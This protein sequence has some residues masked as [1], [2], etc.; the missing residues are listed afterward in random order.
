VNLRVVGAG[1]GRTGTHSLK[2]ALEQLL[3][4]PCHHMVEVFAHPE[5]LPRWRDAVGGAP[6]DAWG[7]VY[8]GYV[9]T[10]D[11]PGCRFWAEL[12]EANPDAI[13]LLSVRSSADE[14]WTSAS[15]TIFDG[16]DA[17]PDG[18]WRRWAV[19]L[20]EGHIGDFRDEAAAKAGYER[21]NAAVRAAIPA[22]RL[23]EW[24][25]T[26]G[27][28]P[29]CDALGVPVPAEPFPRTNTTEEWQARRR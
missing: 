15:N 6:L 5:Q 3:G 4:G 12:A 9:A 8:D 29:L 7:G 26:D 18:D 10:V 2:L 19:D 24:R 13:V 17:V 22:H 1:L 28:A 23:L 20:I 27:W 11:W 21:H 16:M 25:A 14:W